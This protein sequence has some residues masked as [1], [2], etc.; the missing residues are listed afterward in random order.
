MSGRIL[1]LQFTNPA[2]YPPLQHSAR[3][4][5]DAGWQVL[6]LGIG[7][8]ETRE[9]RV[10]AHPNI[11]VKLMPARTVGW[12]RNLNMGWFTLWVLWWTVRWRPA[13]LYAS[14]LPATPA[15]WL[16]SQ[17]SFVRV[18]Y[19]EHDTPTVTRGFTAKFMQFRARLAQRAALCVLPNAERADQFARSFGVGEK[20]QVVWNCPE[21]AEAVP[22]PLQAAAPA[23]PFRLLY[24]GS[25]V[26]SRLPV[27]V[28]EALAHLP[29]HVSLSVV[30][31]ETIGHTGYV[32]SLLARARGL[33]V[34]SRVEWLGQVP[35]RAE[36]LAL[37]RAC[38]VGIALMP[39]QS[40]D[41]NERTMAGASNKPFD[42]MACGLGLIISDLEDWRALFSPGDFARVCN[43]DD[44]GSIAAAVCWYLE[45]PAE[46]LA[47]GERARQKILDAWNYE[48]RFAPV[49]SRIVE[50]AR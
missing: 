18:V 38:E 1:Y 34:E 16:A 7:Y 24:H 49:F 11:V 17:L 47:Q 28:V 12:R 50:G 43:S 5:A 39:M 14:D 41:P 37:A 40:D 6:F 23:A 42:Y 2:G 22:V 44:A 31:Y 20:T 21:R 36:L 48:T 45:H 15:A 32:E 19:H 30:G 10:P 26:P 25:V 35:T 29:A 46:R 4:L 8:A 33:G 13:W 27:A 3:M 9:M